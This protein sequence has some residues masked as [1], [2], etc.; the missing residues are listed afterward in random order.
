MH[1]KTFFSLYDPTLRNTFVKEQL[2]VLGISNKPFLLAYHITHFFI[3]IYNDILY[4][5]LYTEVL[6]VRKSITYN[7]LIYLLTSHTTISIAL[8]VSTYMPLSLHAHTIIEINLYDAHYILDL[9]KYFSKR[10]F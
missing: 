3:K 10:Q 6:T 2:L 1:Y 7:I 8:S 9:S 4:S 5:L